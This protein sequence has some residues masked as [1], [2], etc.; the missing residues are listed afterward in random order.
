MRWRTQGR[1]YV[2]E[3][4]RPIPGLTVEVWDKDV[5]TRDD[6]LGQAVTD[7]QG[8]WAVEYDESAFND[9]GLDADPDLYV[10][11]RLPGPNGRIVLTSEGF[12]RDNADQNETFDLAVSC[13]SFQSG[14]APSFLRLRPC[15]HGVVRVAGTRERLR[16]LD[17]ALT[18]SRGEVY[19]RTA[20]KDGAYAIWMDTPPAEANLRLALPAGPVLV[21]VPVL[22]T[23]DDPTSQDFEVDAALLDELPADVAAAIRPAVPIETVSPPWRR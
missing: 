16:G 5:V 18:S 20:L 13:W 2:E 10:K 17:V 12:V 19:A 22:V 1:V 4:R 21:D 14:D 9:F 6:F 11:V 3:T 15:M 7:A 23:P 8:C